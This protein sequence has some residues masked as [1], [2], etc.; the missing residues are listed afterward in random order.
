MS[1]ALHRSL[2]GLSLATQKTVTY[3]VAPASCRAAQATAQPLRRQFGTLFSPSN[4]LRQAKGLRSSSKTGKF[5]QLNTQATS[6][7]S[8]PRFMARLLRVPGAGA[9][10]GAGGLTYVNHK[11]DRKCNPQIPYHLPSCSPHAVL[12]L[13]LLNNF[14]DATAEF[15]N[16]TSEQIKIAQDRSMDNL[17]SS[18][19]GIKFAKGGSEPS[20]RPA[21]KQAAIDA[22]IAAT[23]SSSSK[24]DNEKD[25]NFSGAGV[26]ARGAHPLTMSDLKVDGFNVRITWYPPLQI[27]GLTELSSH[28]EL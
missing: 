21:G 17:D 15:R 28:T 1:A 10:I 18:I 13:Y 9:I 23:V 27:Q 4:A 12:S 19:D 7:S 16:Q 2:Y 5:R 20:G 25:E 24:L 6:Y 8:I 3:G 26:D 11:I 14:T 22:A